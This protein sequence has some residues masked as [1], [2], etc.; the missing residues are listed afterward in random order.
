MHLREKPVSLLPL[1]FPS[2]RQRYLRVPPEYAYECIVQILKRNLEVK[3]SEIRHP[4]SLTLTASL[5]G[6]IGADL[7]IHVIPEGDISVL[8]LVFSY[9]KMAGLASSLLAVTVLLSLL[10]NN[11]LP[12]IGV[13][14]LIPMAY[15]INF[16]VTRFLNVLNEGLPLIEQRYAYESLLKNRERWRKHLKDV[17]K[18]REKLRKKHIKAWGSTNILNYKI[19][20][21]KS[22]G[23]TYEEAIIK[24]SEEEGIIAE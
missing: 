4:S 13:F 2:N 9:R 1:M 10:F 5:G 18:L 16:K 23:L 3:D 17:E 21:Y 15:N 11:P 8:N 6:K 22:M 14:I 19:E 20:E 24:I 12:M 7:E